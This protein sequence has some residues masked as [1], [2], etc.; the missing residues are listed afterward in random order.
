MFQGEIGFGGQIG[1]LIRAEIEH[2][3]DPCIDGEI[4]VRGDDGFNGI[5]NRVGQMDDGGLALILR[6][7]GGLMMTGHRFDEGF[8]QVPL[9]QQFGAQF[10]MIEAEFVALQS[11]QILVFLASPGQQPG[12]GLGP[13]QIHDQLADIVQ[14]A[15]DKQP[16]G[17]CNLQPF[18]QS[19]GGTGHRNVVAPEELWCDQPFGQSVELVD[20]QRCHSQ[21]AQLSGADDGDGHGDGIDPGRETVKRAVHDF[22]Q[23]GGQCGILAER[24][25]NIGR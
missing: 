2:L 8:G 5:A 6:G 7:Q 22:Q 4:V 1:Q 20:H 9:A 25:G 18:S 11:A 24:F 3:P 21:V 23:P 16:F 15:G 12:R 13:G 19:P 17:M 14:Q 10:G